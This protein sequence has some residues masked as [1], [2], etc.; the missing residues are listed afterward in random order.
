MG[1]SCV[2]M[3]QQEA[4]YT[5]YMFH[6]MVYNPA[7][8]GSS[9]SI[10]AAVLL[11]DQWMGLKLDPAAPGM[12][13]GS[14]PMNG[15]F[16]FDTPV[17]WLHG[18]IGLAVATEKIGYHKN[19]GV[20]FDYAFR[21]FYGQGTL[22]AGFEAS[23]YNATL[24]LSQLVG[25]DD[26][27]GNL[28]DPFSSSGDP[29]L[30]SSQ[31]ESDFLVDFS[32]GIYFQKYGSY[33][34]GVSVKNLLAAKS[35]N[36]HWQNARNLYFLGGYTYRLPSNPSVLIQPSALLKASDFNLRTLQAEASCI[37]NYQNLFWGG[38]SYR[39]RDAVA[40]LGGVQWK[41]LRVGLS[42]DLTTSRLG[43][44][45]TGRSQGTLELDIKYCFRVVIPPKPPTIYR[46]THYLL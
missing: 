36:M 20:N 26:Y 3:A 37:I 27:S 18:G 6:R 33:Y 41:K 38:A 30:S 8:V 7:T 40:L 1:L 19:T 42:Y 44:F 12:D 14:T 22:S 16:L 21:M 5:Q 34:W 10:C 15:Q 2:G 24:D 13:P 28:S 23:F 39:F 9:G 35:D 29:L 11:R 32:T 45:K 17:K 43:T 31:V 46:N 4:Q 25:T